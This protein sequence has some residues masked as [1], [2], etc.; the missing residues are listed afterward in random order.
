LRP[1]GGRIE[2]DGVE[3]TASR[4]AA[5][6]AQIAYV[7]QD[8]FL[9]NA[10]V[11]ANVCWP[12]EPAA[13][14]AIW[15]ALSRAAA[16]DFVAALPDGLDT[17]IGDRGSLLSAGE[18]QRLAIAR[19]LLRRPRLI[20]F[21]EATSSLDPENEA[22]IQ[23]AI[24]QLHHRM[25]VLV[26][27]HRLWTIRRADIIHVLDGGRLVQSGTWDQLQADRQGRFHAL[28]GVDRVR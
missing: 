11:R 26:I 12:A 9:F 16:A 25:T 17:V 3:L 8:A 2:V 13:D 1:T 4:L 15:E 27:A 10:T 5:W 28:A 19:A 18:R 24:D 21:D 20:V 23:E 14:A 6:R 7:P 22:R